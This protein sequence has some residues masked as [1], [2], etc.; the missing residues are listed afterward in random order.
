MIFEPDIFSKKTPVWNRIAGKEIN[1]F[2]ALC[3]HIPRLY[4]LDIA[5]VYYSGAFEINS[6]NYRIEST[7]GKSILLK[8]WPLGTK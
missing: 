3:K 7:D 8:K 4:V 1:I 6:N 2:K 5:A